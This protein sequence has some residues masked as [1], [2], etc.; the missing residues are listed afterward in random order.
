MTHSELENCT[1]QAHGDYES[2][3]K[4]VGQPYVRKDAV[5]KVTGQARYAFDLEIPGMLHAKTLH[6][7]HARAKIVSID[8]SKAEALVG[9]KAIVTGEGTDI[10]VGLYMQDKLAIAKGE[11]RYQGEVVAAVAATTEA[12]AEQAI[13]L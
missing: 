13:S 4:H 12:I 11:T 8:T 3:Y 5:E 7:P 6:S 9:V 2:S 1:Y 10:L